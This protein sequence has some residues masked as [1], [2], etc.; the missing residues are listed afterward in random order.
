VL[1]RALGEREVERVLASRSTGPQGITSG[2]TVQRTTERIV[3]ASE[4]SEL[5]DLTAYVA[6]A[7]KQPTRLVSITPQNLPVVATAMEE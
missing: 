3:M 1:S 4:I 5:P 6:L 7:G 2:E